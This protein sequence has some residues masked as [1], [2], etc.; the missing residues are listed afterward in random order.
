MMR[1]SRFPVLPRPENPKALQRFYRTSKCRH[2]AA[3]VA[4]R[5]RYMRPT[6]VRG[7]LGLGN[8]HVSRNRFFRKRSRVSLPHTNVN[9]SGDG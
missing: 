2:D 4:Y 8:I 1:S 6:A 5:S 7:V 3:G 9:H